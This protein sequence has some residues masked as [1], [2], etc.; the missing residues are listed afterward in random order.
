MGKK[1][2]D[3]RLRLVHAW[4]H[5]PESDG[6]VAS[7]HVTWAGWRMTNQSSKELRTT[8]RQGGLDRTQA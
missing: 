8:W 3:Q 6:G 7:A 5:G 4:R 2:D 1:R